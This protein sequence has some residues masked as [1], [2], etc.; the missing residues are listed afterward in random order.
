MQYVEATDRGE[1]L[2]LR[3]ELRQESEMNTNFPSACG[4][5]ECAAPAKLLPA[6]SLF[7][8]WH[9]ASRSVTP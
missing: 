2:L 9:F 8:A 1:F 3:C 4:D 7:C 5:I 6:M